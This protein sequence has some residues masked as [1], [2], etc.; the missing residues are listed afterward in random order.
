VGRKQ[1]KERYGAEK[2]KGKAANK[3]NSTLTTKR[4]YCQNCGV[5]NEQGTD[6]K[7]SQ[8]KGRTAKVTQGKVWG[9]KPKERLE[10]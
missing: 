1:R 2:V 7:R 10:G 4:R 3:T 5:K 9:K 6:A 8:R